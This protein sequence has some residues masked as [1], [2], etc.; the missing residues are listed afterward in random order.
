MCQHIDINRNKKYSTAIEIKEGI[1]LTHP[2]NIFQFVK[3]M[4]LYNKIIENHNSPIDR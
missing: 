3:G 1:R 4:R 2:K